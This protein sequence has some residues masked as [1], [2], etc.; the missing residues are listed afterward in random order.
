MGVLGAIVLPQSLFMTAGQVHVPKTRSVGAELVGRQQFRRE[1]LFLEKLAHQSE[2]SRLVAPALNQHA[3]N[4]ALVVDGAPQVHPLAGNANHHLVEVPPVARAWAAPSQL[5]C[6]PGPEFQNP[7]P[8]RFIRNLQAALGEELPDVAVA[9]CEPEIKPNRVLDDRRREAMPSV[10]ELIHASSLPHRL[11]PSNSVSVTTPRSPWLFPDKGLRL[12]LLRGNRISKSLRGERVLATVRRFGIGIHKKTNRS[13]FL[14]RQGEVTRVVEADPI[15][16]PISEQAFPQR[17]DL[18]TV[19]WDLL[20]ENDLAHI[21]RVDREPASSLNEDFGPTMLR[22]GDVAGLASDF[23]T[24]ESATRMPK[25]SRAGSPAARERPT[26]NEFISAHLPPRSPDSSMKVMS[27]GGDAGLRARRHHF[28]A[29]VWRSRRQVRGYKLVVRWPLS[30][31]R[32]A[33]ARFLRHPRR[34]L[35]GVEIARQG[36]RRHQGAALSGRS[37]H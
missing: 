25:K 36:R 23:D 29:G 26:Y 9:Q 28:H 37:L 6:D 3:E 14:L 19:N 1:A 21:C 27:P 20:F 5:T 2:R 35:E 31:C 7:A 18:V 24:F 22:L 4:L 10:G 16:L 17:L 8:H 13:F 12:N 32:A 30:G 34:R 33:G 15:H 11:A